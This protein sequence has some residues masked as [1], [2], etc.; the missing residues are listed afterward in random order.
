MYI[1]DELKLICIVFL[2]V[3]ALIGGIMRL[4]YHF[5]K[6]ICYTKYADYQPEYVGWTTGC[7]I[8]VDEQ[9]VPADSLRM[10]L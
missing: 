2:I 7:M 3:F 10:T 6:K 9:R 1:D 4:D 8:T 5:D